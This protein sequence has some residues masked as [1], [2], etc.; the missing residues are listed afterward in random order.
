MN[1]KFIVLV[2]AIFLLTASTI[3]VFAASDNETTEICHYADGS[4]A[5]ITTQIIKNNHTTQSSTATSR[6]KSAKTTFIYYNKSNIKEWVFVLNGTFSYDGKTAK[7][8]SASTNSLIYVSGWKCTE[9]NTT[10]SGNIIKSTFTFKKNLFSKVNG[11]PLVSFPL[12]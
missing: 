12:R 1:R 3:T 10:K 5:V 6:T 9:K 11:K 8:I 7:A 4:Y 2:I